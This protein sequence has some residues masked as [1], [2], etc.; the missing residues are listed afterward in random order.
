MFSDRTR[1]VRWGFGRPLAVATL[2]VVVAAAAGRAL[3]Q[4]AP[5]DGGPWRSTSKSVPATVVPAAAAPNLSD[6]TGAWRSST[7]I[8]PPPI[9]PKTAQQVPPVVGPAPPPPLGPLPKVP[10]LPDAKLAP[11]PLD[12]TPKPVPNFTPPPGAVPPTPIERTPA[13]PAPPPA[14]VPPTAVKPPAAPGLPTVLPPTPAPTVA[15][16]PPPALTPPPGIAPQDDPPSVGL[17]APKD[18]IPPIRMKTQVPTTPSIPPQPSP[19]GTGPLPGLA[20]PTGPDSRLGEPRMLPGNEGKDTDPTKKDPAQADVDAALLNSARNAVRA[21]DFPL[22]ITRYNSYL[23]KEKKDLAV[24]EELAGAYQAADIVDKATLILEDVIRRDPDR[25]P[26]LLIILS[27]L[28][29]RD[30]KYGVACARLKEAIQLTERDDKKDDKKLKEYRLTAAARLAQLQ[31]AEDQY[32]LAIEIYEKFFSAAKPGDTDLPPAFVTLLLDLERSAEA[33]AFLGPLL[34][35]AP[36]D[37]ELLTDRVRAYAMLGDRPKTATAIAALT[38][39]IPNNVDARQELAANLVGSE[40]FDPALQVIEQGMSIRQANTPPHVPLQIT[41]A[42]LFLRRYQ[43]MASRAELEHIQ[44]P[45]SPLRERDMM[46]TKAAWFVQAGEYVQAKRVYEVLIERDFFDY[47]AR[48]G[49]G[50]THA[51]AGE[52]ERAK[53]EYCKVPPGVRQYRPARRGFATA[54]SYQ[55][56]FK[57]AVDQIDLL[58]REA[59]WDA[60]TVVVFLQILE[61][62]KENGRAK[63]V[64]QAYLMTKPPSPSAEAA[65]RAALG[66]VDLCTGK[67][68]D[69]ENNL[70]LALKLSFGKSA[71][72][73]YGLTK[74]GFMFKDP[75]RFPSAFL[76]D[77]PFDELRYRILLSDMFAADDDDLHSLDFARAAQRLDPINPAVMTRVADGELRV[78]RQTGNV[79]PAVCAAKAVLDISPINTRG[80]LSLARA[81]A[82]GQNYKASVDAYNKLLS[83]DRDA[84]T[85]KRELA[86]IYYADH[87][88]DMSKGTYQTIVA[89][90]DPEKAFRQTLSSMALRLPADLRPGLDGLAG[91]KLSPE[92]LKIEVQKMAAG[93]KD[94][95]LAAGLQAAA[96]DY[97]ARQAEARGAD[98]EGRAKYN[99]GIRDL[100]AIP[101]YRELIAYEPDNTEAMFDVG[102]IY[103]TRLMTKSAL[104]Q[105][106]ELLAADPGHREAAI[107]SDRHLADDSPTY[108]FQ[109]S[110]EKEFGFN[111]LNNISRL[112]IGNFFTVPIGDEN[113][114][115]GFG[116]TRIELY[117]PAGT[118]DQF[119]VVFNQFGQPFTQF[120]PAQ[121]GGNLGGNIPTFLYQQRFASYDQLLF[122][123]VINVEQY[124]NRVRTRPTGEVGLINY[125]DGWRAESFLFLNNVLE[126]G[127]SLVQDIYRY[128]GRLTGEYQATRRFDVG[129]QVRVAGYSDAN[130]LLETNGFGAYLLC[131]APTQLRFIASVNTISFSNVTQF[132][133]FAAADPSNL[134]GTVHPYFAP[135]G[136]TFYDA[137]FDWRHWLSRDY[138][139]HANQCYYTVQAGLRVD[140]RSNTYGLLNAGVNYD[141]NSEAT[142]GADARVV[143]SD[144]YRFGGINFYFIWRMPFI[145]R[146]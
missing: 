146:F 13:P 144:V 26:R 41:K 94:P 30:R 108:R 24:W 3:A 140:S 142:I 119:G 113:E 50:N 71:S 17:P 63:Q 34:E 85:P 103:S 9:P 55:R 15:A 53:A 136:F 14:L 60:Q 37:P 59:P 107:A 36:D 81:Y 32:P 120:F 117:P 74:V 82:I 83:A 129:G 46:L 135:S 75:G 18:Y 40:D 101:I 76:I 29:V 19:Q 93:C 112:R 51:A 49:L 145:S 16:V 33:L 106:S 11:V 111:G 88:Y 47:D 102:Q 73:I 66:R 89:E 109:T 79:E 122:K 80:F 90:A 133:P 27:S 77:G 131:F 21:R 127:Q 114:Y 7:T 42:E 4:P 72:A 91:G 139:S 8:L 62:M 121:Q 1:R 25:G 123:S 130:T 78:A 98:L 134:V 20:E 100:T 12:S 124:E 97:E 35:A 58:A 125:G 6:P 43:M 39:K 52:L 65:V 116:Y 138:F 143:W 38:E 96:T 10:L 61:R 64:A 48:L 57:P 84:V 99:K 137:I 70:K 110:F 95:L 28:A 105:Y 92:E 86:R 44:Q 115:V 2:G 69:G 22:A 104:N 45:G 87:Y 67:G 126:N 118:P 56:K 128:G 68:A 132:G 5:T 31:I 23:A 141:I 54:L